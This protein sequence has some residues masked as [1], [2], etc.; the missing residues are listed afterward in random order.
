MA[1][2]LRAR[3]TG[4]TC[5]NERERVRKDEKKGWCRQGMGCERPSSTFATLLGQGF[6]LIHEL[7]DVLELSV[8]RGKPNIGDLVQLMQLLHDFLTH[9][10]TFNLAFAH[11]LDA[12]FNP[13]CHGFDRGST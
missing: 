9:N 10:P 1:M 3:A 4:A 11:F 6:Q 2:R 5:S 7:V 12:L 8:H 13:I